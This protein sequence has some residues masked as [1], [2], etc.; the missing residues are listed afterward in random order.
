MIGSCTSCLRE[1]QVIITPVVF[2]DANKHQLCGRCFNQATRCDD[3]LTIGALT[4][5]IDLPRASY[6]V[7]YK[8]QGG[9][10][11]NARRVL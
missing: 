8:N 7:R 4:Y 11:G 1:E 10:L 9:N 3:G 2:N 6:L 5:K